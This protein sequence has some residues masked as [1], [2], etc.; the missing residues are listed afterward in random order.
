MLQNPH[1]ALGGV[2]VQLQ[3]HDTLEI[4]ALQQSPQAFEPFDK[5]GDD[6]LFGQFLAFHADTIQQRESKCQYSEAKMIRIEHL[7]YLKRYDI[8]VI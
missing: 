2:K 7:V 8:L 1:I 4:R 6:H 3:M 5:L